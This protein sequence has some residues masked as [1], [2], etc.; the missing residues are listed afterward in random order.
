MLAKLDADKDGT[1]SKTEF[2]AMRRKKAD[3]AKAQGAKAGRGDRLWGR[4]DA[5]KD[6]F[7]SRADLESM[8]AKRFQR[9]DAD[10]DGVLTSADRQAAAGKAKAMM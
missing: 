9:M 2:E 4:V 6:G 8:A 7:L 10:G 1:L 3:G 5:D